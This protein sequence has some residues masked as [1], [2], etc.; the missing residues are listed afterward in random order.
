VEGL[1]NGIRELL[2]LIPEADPSLA[3]QSGTRRSHEESFQLATNIHIYAS[4][5]GYMGGIIDLAP[6]KKPAQNWRTVRVAQ[7]QVGNTWNPEPRAWQRMAEIM[8]R[9]CKVKVEAKPIDPG[10]GQLAGYQVAHLTGTTAFTFTPAQRD[11]LKAFVD[12]GGL[13]LID[14]AGGSPEFADEA[15]NE[16]R[17]IFGDSAKELD[18]L[19]P[20]TDF[21]SKQPGFESISKVKCRIFAHSQFSDRAHASRLRAI[22]QKGRLAVIFSREDLTAGMAGIHSDGIL[23]YDVPTASA[24]VCNILLYALP[25]G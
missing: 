12:H 1:S 6:A 5:R 10:P 13:L 14:A 24:I 3:W 11:E 9:N 17:L 18:S 21:D 23:G 25:P 22:H 19:I 15:E 2:L 4:D 16:L 7:L 8:E 20:V